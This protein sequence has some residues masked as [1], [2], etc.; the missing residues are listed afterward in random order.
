MLRKLLLKKFVRPWLAVFVFGA[1]LSIGVLA[2]VGLRG[3]GQRGQSSTIQF[4]VLG[5]ASGPNSEAARAQPAN[6]L[7]I[8]GQVYLVDAGDGAVAQLAKA[9]LRLAAVRAVFLSHLHFDHTGGM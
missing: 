2:Q 9:N 5:T 1:L 8:G 7:T 3:A 4:I 6:A